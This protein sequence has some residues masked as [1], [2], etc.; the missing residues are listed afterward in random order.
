MSVQ[1]VH[2]AKDCDTR[3]TDWTTI[4]AR[5]LKA[6]ATVSLVHQAERVRR[7]HDRAVAEEPPVSSSKP[8]PGGI[9]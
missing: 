6:A 5:I 8:R 9:G 3:S 7:W 4:G 1:R 2:E